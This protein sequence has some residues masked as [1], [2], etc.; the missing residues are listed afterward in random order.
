MSTEQPNLPPIATPPS[1]WLRWLPGLLMLKHYQ[2]AWLPKDI[3]AGLVLT[4]MAA[5]ATAIA[6]ARA[7]RAAQALT[8]A[9]GLQ[10][11]CAADLA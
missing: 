11:P 1:G 5:E 10:L 4:T 3:I 2:R 7:V 8:T 6:T 9:D